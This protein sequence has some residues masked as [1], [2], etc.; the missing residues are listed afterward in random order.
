MSYAG[1]D[2]GIDK[3]NIGTSGAEIGGPF[4]HKKEIGDGR[5]SSSD[6]CKVSLIIK[7]NQKLFSQIA[8]SAKY[9]I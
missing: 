4:G 5:K 8:F 9:L 3:E 7:K 6:D 2:C 1:T